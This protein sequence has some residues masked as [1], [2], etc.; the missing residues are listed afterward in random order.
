MLGHVWVSLIKH[1][2]VFLVYTSRELTWNFPL[3]QEKGCEPDISVAVHPK[4]CFVLS[5]D[6]LEITKTVKTVQ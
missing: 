6:A 5:L 2:F 4:M 1:D 3:Q